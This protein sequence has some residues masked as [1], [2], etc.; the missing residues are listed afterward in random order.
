MKNCRYISIL[1]LFILL[2]TSC[3]SENNKMVVELLTSSENKTLTD[4]QNSQMNRRNERESILNSSLNNNIIKEDVDGYMNSFISDYTM[5]SI[6]VEAYDAPFIQSTEGVEIK[7]YSR[8]DNVIR[9]KMTSYGEMGKTEE[10]YYL[11]DNYM[12]CT[13]VTDIYS[14]SITLSDAETLYRQFD[15]CIMI[16]KDCY[17]YKAYLDGYVM[18][19]NEEEFLN[20]EE[21]QSVFS[22]S[23]GY[24]SSLYN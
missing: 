3:K 4:E 5:G 23:A 10:N 1:I 8:D 18:T 21:L 11:L 9:Y 6:L 12:Y 24:T 17:Q 13:I 7:R 14:G 20:E 2:L 15:E 19:E 22:R 16:G